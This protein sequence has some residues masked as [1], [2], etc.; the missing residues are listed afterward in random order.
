MKY[1][2]RFLHDTLTST[3]N[4][5]KVRLIFGARQVGKTVLLNQVI[6]EECAVLYNLQDASL[7]KLT[8]FKPP[9][10]V[11]HQARWARFRL[12]YDIRLAGFVIPGE[13]NGKEHNGTKMRFDCNTFYV[14]FLDRDHKFCRT[15]RG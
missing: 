14:V 1:Y 11:P 2:H 12:E 6:S 15:K 9:T 3:T 10:Y 4:L 7:R 5:N 8:L 13:Y